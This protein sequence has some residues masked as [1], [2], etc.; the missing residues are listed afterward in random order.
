MRRA[1]LCLALLALAVPAQERRRPP[2]PPGV[3]ALKDLE[4]ARVGPKSLRLDLYLP[5]ERKGD[6]PVVVWIHGGGWRAGSKDR[7]PAVFL[8]TRGYAVASITYRLSQEATFPAQIHDCKAAIRWLRAHA[9]EHGLDPAR[10]GAW[11]SSA[12]GHLAALLGTSGEVA[13]LEGDLGHADQS[14]RV[15]AVVDF[16]G[17]SDFLA[18]KP[19][20]GRRASPQSRLLGGSV[21]EQRDK[22]AQASPVTHASA[23]DPPFY[24]VHGSEDP[25]VP[26]RQARLLHEALTRHR[27]NAY[28][29]V[30]E[31]AGH[32]LHDPVTHALAGAFFDLHLKGAAK[33]KPAAAR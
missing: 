10:F 28:L 32:G 9:R 1:A 4:F 23:D 7:C 12:G 29:H 30:L 25:V 33:P 14:S 31:G 3:R 8:A 17:P 15:Q 26:V 24:I 11:G 20:R 2:V 13:A 5:Q 27:V 21:E 16:C 6:S 19:R 22:A 18:W